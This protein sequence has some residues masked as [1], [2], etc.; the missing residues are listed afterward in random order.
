MNFILRDDR[1]C[2]DFDHFHLEAEL[3]KR[4][5]NLPSFTPDL[6]FLGVVG[7]VV[8]LQEQVDVRKLVIV[9]VI[10]SC[11]FIKL[12]HDL[13]PSV[14]FLSLIFNLEVGGLRGFL[15]LLLLIGWRFD[16]EVFRFLFH[17]VF[18]NQFIL[19][20][21][22]CFLFQ[23]QFFVLLGNVVRLEFFFGRPPLSTDSNLEFV[24]V[25]IVLRK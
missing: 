5:F 10:R 17:L 9:K 8:A 4:L 14:F 2:F 13:G 22:V 3:R 1:S 16:E 7:D 23:L 12:G 11:G 25:E 15:T 18:F 19:K 24:F 21:R 20:F 6:L